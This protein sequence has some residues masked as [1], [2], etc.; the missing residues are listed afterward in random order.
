MYFKRRY[1]N[2]THTARKTTLEKGEK[3]KIHETREYRRTEKRERQLK[4][5]KGEGKKRDL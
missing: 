4:K 3:G 2:K 5:A 1:S